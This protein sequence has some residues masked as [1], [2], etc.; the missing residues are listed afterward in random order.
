MERLC[1]PQQMPI[2][3]LESHYFQEL[4]SFFGEAVLQYAAKLTI[5]PCLAFRK[6]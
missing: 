4:L 2:K 1:Q 5:K 6:C 3:V